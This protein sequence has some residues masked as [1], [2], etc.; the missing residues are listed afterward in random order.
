MRR[1][2]GLSYQKNKGR[3]LGVGIACDKE[4]EVHSCKAEVL[5][6]RLYIG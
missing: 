2:C 6:E 1:D 5:R 4:T 3:I